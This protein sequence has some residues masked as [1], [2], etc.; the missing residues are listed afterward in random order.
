MSLKFDTLLSNYK[1]LKEKINEFEGQYKTQ[2]KFLL[3]AKY[4]TQAEIEH[5]IINTGHRVFGENI[6]QDALEKWQDIKTNDIELHFI[7]KIQSNKIKKIVQLFDVIETVDSE[8]LACKI[9]AEA[10]KQNKK[11]KMLLQVNIGNEPQKSGILPDE[12]NEVF[13]QI[14]DRGVDIDGIM[15]IPPQ[16]GPAFFYFGCMQKIAKE[17][18][19][20]ELSM[21]MSNDFETAIKFGASIIRIGSAILE[22]TAE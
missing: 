9:Y 21:G 11:I 22:Y 3:A 16:D 15:C 19:L 4:L 18:Q 1:L 8:S 5:I 14:K 2:V 17:H 12:F 6:V 13:T 7:G 20:K 10:Q